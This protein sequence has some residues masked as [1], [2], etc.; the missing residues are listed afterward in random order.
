MIP[1]AARAMLLHAPLRVNQSTSLLLLRNTARRAYT[2]T[3]EA[4]AAAENAFTKERA[5]IKH[6]AAETSGT[7]IPSHYRC[8]TPLTPTTNC[9]ILITMY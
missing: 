3:P 4:K 2:S 5:A 1:T 7:F 6:H 8:Q 9:S